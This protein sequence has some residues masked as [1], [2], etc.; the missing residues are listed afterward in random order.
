MKYLLD[1]PHHRDPFDR[2]LITQ[3]NVEN[4]SL[5]THDS[6]ISSIYRLG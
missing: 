5:V 6:Q 4:L 1:T 3:A 2:L